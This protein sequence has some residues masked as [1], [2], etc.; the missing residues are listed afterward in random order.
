MA[1]VSQTVFWRH[2]FNSLCSS[3]DLEEYIVLEVEPVRS[4]G[5]LPA[6]VHSPHNK[7][8]KGLVLV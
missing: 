8:L 5:H 2:P 3:K 1:E 7:V 4:T 6:T